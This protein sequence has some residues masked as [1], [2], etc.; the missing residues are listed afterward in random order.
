MFKYHVH[1][2]GEPG[3]TVDMEEPVNTGDFIHNLGYFLVVTSKTFFIDEKEKITAVLLA[4]YH[5]EE[6][7]E[8][9]DE[10]GVDDTSFVPDN[11]D[12]ES[13]CVPYSPE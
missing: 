4:E 7:Y 3:F 6:E 5:D 11:D 8:D 2:D 10:D 13:F 9:E 12:L 1:I